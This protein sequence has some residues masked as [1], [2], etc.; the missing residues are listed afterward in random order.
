[1]NAIMRLFKASLLIGWLWGCWW[2]W[3][4][5]FYHVVI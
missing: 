2:R 4:R 3:G 5:I 1:M